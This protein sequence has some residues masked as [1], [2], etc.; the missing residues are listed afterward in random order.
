MP[1]PPDPCADNS[2]HEPETC[3]VTGC[4][5]GQMCAASGACEPVGVL[6]PD[7]GGVGGSFVGTRGDA[8]APSCLDIEVSYQTVIPTVSLLIDRSSSMMGMTGNFGQ[9]VQQEVE[10]GTYQPWGCPADPGAPADDPDQLNFDWRWNVVRNVLFNPESGVVPA[11]QNDVRFGMTLFTHDPD[12]AP[13]VCPE[14]SVADFAL[15]NAAQLLSTMKCD[16]LGR[17]TPTRE[18]LV[19]A[20]EALHDLDVD[21]PKLIILATDGAP[22]TCAC[23]DFL[24]EPTTPEECRPGST[25]FWEG[26]EV[27]PQQVASLEVVAE[28]R[29]IYEEWGIRISVIDLSS[30]GEVS[31]REHLGDVAVA[32]GGNLYDG[33]KPTGLSAAFFDSVEE[34]RSCEVDLKGEIVAGYEDDGTVTLDG[35]PLDLVMAGGNGYRVISSS[36][37]ELSGQACDWLKQGDHELH[38]T[39]PCDTFVEVK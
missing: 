36:R 5:E 2:C 34:V 20:A 27:T 14:L 37:I 31:L 22:T 21:G 19:A 26:S 13:G 7:V 15:G 28:A 39:F 29:R 8:G 30:V 35:A 1:L 17:F 16:D 3:Q 24:D 38:I 25:V 9:D 10:A 33:L 11:F 4:P 6:A 23:T 18:S 32:G 12:G